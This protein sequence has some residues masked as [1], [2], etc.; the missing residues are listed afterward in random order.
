V[1]RRQLLLLPALLSAMA[2]PVAPA[3]AGEDDPT[4]PPTAPQPGTAP[5]AAKLIVKQGCVI[6]IRA[7]VVATA[8][9]AETVAFYL[10]G[11]L[12]KTV[13]P[14]S[15]G[16]AVISMRCSRL[17]VGAHRG[18]A[19][20]SYASSQQTLRFQITRARQSSPQFTG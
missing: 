16:R 3:L 14:S 4:A 12:V 13:N 18:R 2:L 6:G 11:E 8:P 9:G 1:S 19:V 5:V 20:A 7:K 15:R 10:D 17:S